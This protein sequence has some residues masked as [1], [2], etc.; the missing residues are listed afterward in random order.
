MQRGTVALLA[1]GLA[2][3]LGNAG[4]SRPLP[5]TEAQYYMNAAAEHQDPI[6]RRIRIVAGEVEKVN[7]R[8]YQ[9][10][11]LTMERAGLPPEIRRPA[12]YWGLKALS[13]RVPLAEGSEGQDPVGDVARYIYYAGDSEMLEYRD[14]RTGKA[15]L[16]EYEPFKKYLLPTIYRESRYLDGFATTGHFIGHT[17]VRYRNRPDW[18]TLDFSQAKILNLRPDYLIGSQVDVREIDANVPHDQMSFRPFT[19]EEYEEMM[20][21]GVNHFQ[22]SA[23]LLPW[24][25]QHPV[26]YRAPGQYPFDLFRSNYLATRMYIDEPAIRFGW[27]EWVPGSVASPEI[28]ANAIET[29]VHE[30]QLPRRRPL[31]MQNSSHYGILPGYQDPSASWETMLWTAN[32]QMAGNASALVY[33]G[34]YRERGYGWVPELLLGNGLDGLTVRQQFDYFNSHLRGAARVQGAQWGISVYNEGEQRLMAPAFIRAY[35]QGARF[36]WFWTYGDL[37]YAQRLRVARAL[38]DHIAK[39]PRSPEAETLKM[40]T[41]AIV[42]P[43][44]YVPKEDGIFGVQAEQLTPEGTSYREIAAAALFEGILL[45]R[46]GVEYDTVFDSPRVKDAGYRQLIYIHPDGSV[47]YQ[48]AR[49]TFPALRSA[50][51]VASA[52]NELSIRHAPQAGGPER[53]E[54]ARPGLPGVREAVQVTGGQDTPKDVDYIIPLKTGVTVDGSLADWS[55]VQWIELSGEPYLLGDNWRFETFLDIPE[56]ANPQKPQ[57]Y[58]GFKWDAVSDAYR[59]QFMLEGYHPDE[60][61]ITEVYPGSPAAKAGLRAGDRIMYM[62]NR[63]MRWPFEVWGAVDQSK[64]MPG[65]QMRFVIQRGGN[66][67]NSGREDL[68]VRASFARTETHLLLA[69]EV[70]DDIHQQTMWPIDFWRNDSLQIAL[71]PVLARSH[72]FGDHG[73]EISF[74]LQDGKPLVFRAAGRMGQPLDILKN[75][76][77]AIR[78]EEGRTIYEAAIPFYELHPLSPDMWPEI[79]LSFVV[80]DSDDGMSRK[81]RIEWSPWALTAGKRLFDFPLVRFETGGQSA[82]LSAAIVWK[83]RSARVNESLGLRIAVASAAETQAV[84]RAELKSLDNPR[85]RPVRT[86]VTIPVTPRVHEFDLALTPDA[87]PGR[88]HLSVQALDSSGKTVAQDALPVYIYR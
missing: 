64:R 26:F 35:D 56:D 50:S 4:I 23:D 36:F 61:I 51:L 81:S 25:R 8:E 18:P 63:N 16:P 85:A 38:R 62:L 58:L 69:A 9:W 41:T 34:R 74:A 83:S 49:R 37:N 75:V 70:L 73:H 87:D 43:A 42:L 21:A 84:V 12:E 5:G 22:P 19:R 48:P 1:V 78:R 47:Q 71:D 27:D 13:E 11:E 14:A 17:L 82:H 46:A 60:V 80:N 15:L 57:D 10:W 72:G 30:Y 52:S 2:L 86:E 68:S 33:E 77:V 67:H 88:Y 76:D 7:G 31:E 28:W 54:E 44:G 24:L 65:Q 66:D 32:Y 39:N 55:G 53:L 20:E 29:R 79:G 59:R 3:S 6:L 45:S 40:A